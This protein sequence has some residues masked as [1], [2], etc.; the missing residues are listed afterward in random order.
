MGKAA[1]APPYKTGDA[2]RTYEL[3]LSPYRQSS[4]LGEGAPKGRIGGFGMK[5]L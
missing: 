3:T 4:P 5:A 2:R 1:A